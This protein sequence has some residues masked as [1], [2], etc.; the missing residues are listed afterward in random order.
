MPRL[1]L[2]IDQGTTSTRALL[3]DE[4]GATLAV[5]RRELPQH[6]PAD[7]WVEHEAE[8][9]F[10]D[11]RD[12]AREVLARAAPGD[13]AAVGLSNQRETVVLWERASGRPLHRALVWQ[14]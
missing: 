7:G 6:I 11:A 2:A 8:R 10:G 4:A 1:L 12:V 9:L 5:A 14:D 13:V 3:F